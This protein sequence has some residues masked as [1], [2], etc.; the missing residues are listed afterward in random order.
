MLVVDVLDFEVYVWENNGGDV[1][2]DGGDGFEVGG[3]GG[4]GVV[5]VE[6][7]FYL[8]V[9]GGFVCVVEVEEEEGVFFG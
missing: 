1:L 7:G 5:G 2:V 3:W 6:D 9:K 8:F 4:G